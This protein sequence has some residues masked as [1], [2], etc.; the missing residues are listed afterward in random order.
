[1]NV[2]RPTS[3]PGKR[4]KISTTRS[5]YQLIYE[6]SRVIFYALYLTRSHQQVYEQAY[7]FRAYN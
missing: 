5:K 4:L 6:L 2:L 1:M 7:K 3:V